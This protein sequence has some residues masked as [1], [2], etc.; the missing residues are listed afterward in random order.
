MSIEITLR[1]VSH[2]Y[3]DQVA[4]AGVD[5]VLP[6]GRLIAVV[7]SSGSGKT[8]LLRL[9]AGLEAPDAGEV[10]FDKKAYSGRPEDRPTAMVFQSESLFP[11]LTVAQNIAF[12][13]RARGRRSAWVDEQVAIAMLR[14]GLTGLDDRYPDELS[15]GQARRVAIARA[16][17]RQ[18]GV[19]LLDEPFA[20]LDAPLA[21]TLL[22]QLQ[23]TQRRLGLTMILVT[24]DQEHALLAA[25]HVLV[26]DA[27]RV[28]QAGAPRTV[29]ERPISLFAAQFWGSPAFVDAQVEQIDD[30]PSGRRALVRLFG[31][32][33]SIP[34][35]P[36]TTTG[37]PATVLLRP[38]ALRVERV[39][40][41]VADDPWRRVSDEIGVVEETHYYGDRVEYLVETEAGSLVAS[42]TL[43]AAFIDRGT[44]V[45]LMLDEDRAWVL[46][47]R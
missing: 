8:T 19:L 6:A 4:L 11:D 43:G 26:M 23:A 3:D 46:P 30:S 13:V 18:R 17:V 36:Q 2:K 12:G 31:E 41:V 5:A 28:V 25:D 47:L 33:R 35:H 40:D 39:H 38:H 10:L 24:H 15:G 42:G 20:G 16:M 32:L 14:L 44:A 34:A 21:R 45:R 22:R 7:G 9:I 1:G 27:G 37:G 29:F